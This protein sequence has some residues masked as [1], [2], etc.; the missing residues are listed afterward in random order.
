MTTM[1]FTVILHLS[2]AL[3]GADGYAEAHKIVTETGKPMVVMIGADWCPACQVMKC[4]VIPEV[5]HRG[6]FRRVVFTAVNVD[7]D[8]ELG[9]KLVAN[10]PIPQLVMYR[11]TA[12]GWRVR[13]LVGS[14]S[15]E[16]VQTFIQ[17]GIAADES[18]T[19]GRP[20]VPTP[21]GNPASQPTRAGNK[22]TGSPG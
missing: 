16:A 14:Q 2:L 20:T 7:H 17:E 3:T 12:W 11:R 5:R 22:V 13:R 18:S 4:Q 1:S 10:G 21:A 6:L 15:V 8:R 9:Q 19:G